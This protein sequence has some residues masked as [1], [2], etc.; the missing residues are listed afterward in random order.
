MKRAHRGK[1]SNR[2]RGRAAGRR[3]R[4]AP[5]Q[6][7]TKAAAPPQRGPQ[8]FNLETDPGE[9]TDVAAGNA[10][11]VA[12]LE[13]LI[14]AMNADLGTNGIASGSRPLGRVQ[15]AAPLIG[16]TGRVREGFEPDSAEAPQPT[17]SRPDAASLEPRWKSSFPR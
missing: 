2:P 16:E 13:H 4:R 14:V 12:E 3:A 17:R 11:V 1:I 5:G 10:D 7:R 6:T 9:A 8:L 15:D